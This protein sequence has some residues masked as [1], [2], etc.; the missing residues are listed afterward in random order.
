MQPPP[1][2]HTHSTASDGTLTPTA[3][4]QRAAAAGVQMLALTDHDNTDGLA[5]A[6]QAATEV[7]L[8]VVPG[9]EISVTWNT[10]T[11]HIVGLRLDPNNPALQLGLARLMD[12]RAWRAEEIGRRLA[13]HGIADAYAGA[14]ALASGRLIGRTHFARFLVKQRRAPDTT[15]VFRQFLTRGKP[16]HVPGDWASLEAALGWIHAAG[17]QAVVAH[18]ARYG[19]TRT[20]MQR[21]LGEFRELGG[22]GVEVVSGSHSR[23]E[24]QTFARHAREQQLWAATGSDYHGPENPWIELGRLSPLPEGCIP[25]WRDWPEYHAAKSRMVGGSSTEVY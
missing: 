20:R 19:L 24:A 14:R 6:A 2:L 23:D 1:D 10:L 4:V 3:L 25:I 12:F 17:G 11:V 18:P 13:Q 21:L 9:V 7:G 22:V 5:E 16:G 8:T 15:A